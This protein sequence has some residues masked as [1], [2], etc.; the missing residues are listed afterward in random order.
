MTTKSASEL[1]Y[2]IDEIV[3]TPIQD[4]TE[5][6]YWTEVS[7]PAPSNASPLKVDFPVETLT[8]ERLTELLIDMESQHGMSTLE[9]FRH[10]VREDKAHPENL[11]EWFDLFFLYLGTEEVKRYCRP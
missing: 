10:Y 9:M 4:R 1:N 7:Y 11:E 6:D 5:A 2:E 3:S 8:F